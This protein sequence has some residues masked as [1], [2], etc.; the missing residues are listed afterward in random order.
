M[1]CISL[2]LAELSFQWPR[3]SRLIIQ[4]LQSYFSILN[5]RLKIIS[6]GYAWPFQ[7]KFIPM[8]LGGLQ[9]QIQSCCLSFLSYSF[10][11]YSLNPKSSYGMILQA[12]PCR[13]IT[14]MLNLIGKEPAHERRIEPEEDSM[15]RRVHTN[16]CLASSC[17]RF[18]ENGERILKVTK[19]SGN[20]L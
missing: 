7:D 10:C 19:K 16:V 14:Q 3:Y 9:S 5:Y 15:G 6:L 4:M 11:L 17:L 13:L 12:P 18:P 20:R 2:F 8:G 1:S